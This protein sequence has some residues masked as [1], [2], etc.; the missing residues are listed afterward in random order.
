MLSI[1]NAV[2][3]AGSV[4]DEIKVHDIRDWGDE[5]AVRRADLDETHNSVSFLIYIY[6]GIKCH[7]GQGET[8]RKMRFTPL[9]LS[10]SPGLRGQSS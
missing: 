8:W 9:A 7:I 4:T 10:Q 2:P 5:D 6:I 3:S 1:H